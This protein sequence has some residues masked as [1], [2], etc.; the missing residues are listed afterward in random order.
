M[1]QEFSDGV[2]ANQKLTGVMNKKKVKNSS[3]DQERPAVPFNLLTPGESA[4]MKQ[5]R[6]EAIEIAKTLCPNGKV[7]ED[8][9]PG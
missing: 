6:R 9:K 7:R 3:S 4:Y 8:K 5:K 1:R 2:V